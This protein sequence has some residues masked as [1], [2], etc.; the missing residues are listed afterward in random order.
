MHDSYMKCSMHSISEYIIDFYSFYRQQYQG[1]YLLSFGTR[2]ALSFTNALPSGFL[3]IDSKYYYDR[4]SIL[5]L[6]STE[7]LTDNKKEIKDDHKEWEK[8]HQSEDRYEQG[9]K[10]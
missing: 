1:H 7:A 4:C 9:E 3:L 10:D 6:I 5:Q 2:S 8:S